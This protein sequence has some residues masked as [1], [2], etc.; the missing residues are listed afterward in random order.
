MRLDSGL[1]VVCV[2]A[3]MC[4][5]PSVVHAALLASTSFEATDGYTAGVNVITPTA[6]DTGTGQYWNGPWTGT[7]TSDTATP[8]EAGSTPFGSQRLAIHSNIADPTISRQFQ[9]AQIQDGRIV[10]SMSIRME[11]TATPPNAPYFASDF[12][13]RIEHRTGSNAG[14]KNIQMLFT[15]NGVVQIRQAGGYTD[16]GRWDDSVNYPQFFACKQWAN[17]VLDIDVP[18]RKTTL[19]MNGSL[20]GLYDFNATKNADNI[21]Q[22]RFSGPLAISPST[23]DGLWMDNLRLGTGATEPLPG[24]TAVVSGPAT[25]T[26]TADL[27]LPATPASFAYTIQNNGSQVLNYAVMKTDASGDPA[28]Y[29]W[30]SL[31]KSSGAIDPAGTDTVTASIDTT[32]LANGVHSAWFKFDVGCVPAIRRIDLTIYG[33]RWSVVDSTAADVTT[34]GDS[35]DNV[36]AYLLDYP[37]KPIQTVVHRI[38]NDGPHPVGYTVTKSDAA[39]GCWTLSNDTGTIPVSG[40]AD[41]VATF[42]SAG[43]TGLAT[44]ASYD[45]SL[46]FSDTC[47]SQTLT[48]RIR[49]RYLGVGSTAVFAYDGRVNP[50]ASDSAGPGWTFQKSSD[51]TFDGVVENDNDASD[52]VALRVNDTG[53]GKVKYQLWNQQVSV[54]LTI[55]REVGATYLGRVRVQGYTG[56]NDGGLYIYEPESLCSTAHWGG[57]DGVLVDNKHETDGVAILVGTTDY[58]TVR[59]TVVGEAGDDWACNR[60]IRYYFNQEDLPESEQPQAAFTLVGPADETGNKMGFGFGSG[61]GTGGTYDIAFDWISGTN[62]GAFA[63]GE[64]VAVLGKSLIPQPCGNPFA[65]ADGDGDVDQVDFARFQTCFTGDMIQG[66]FNKAECGCFDRDRNTLVDLS[67]LEKFERCASGP[68]IPAD[69]TCDDN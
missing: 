65:D 45:C 35:C 57:P 66:T 6:P 59:M 29:G 58:V 54:P 61:A 40:Y 69:R 55:Y 56:S 38:R 14:D 50:T 23:T 68:S 12:Q 17:L 25:V 21:N 60:I 19:Y 46:L 32:G 20:I 18:G 37:G 36:R 10:F 2:V 30:L 3:A 63:P 24:C 5:A 47:S 42:D 1:A 64:E 33:C 49:L 31:D 43:L 15:A 9:N 11:P 13:I 53:D 52:G 51:S 34:A 48:R 26:A 8:I 28:T 41:V 4:A 44:E 39:A 62:A 16:L 22:I 7:G 67:D 27:D